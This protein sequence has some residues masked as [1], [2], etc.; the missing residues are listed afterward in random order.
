MADNKKQYANL[1]TLQ[2]FLDN[3]KNL[4]AYKIDVEGKADADHA[5]AISDINELQDELNAI[6]D[7]TQSIT[8]E[9]ID[10]ICGTSIAL[11][12]EVEF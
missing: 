12:S 11:S 6:N 1:G 3:L 2:T 7:A 5:H 4:F 8:N 9:E 10:A